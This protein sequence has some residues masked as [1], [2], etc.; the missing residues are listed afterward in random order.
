[1][2]LSKPQLVENIARELSDNSTGQISPYDIRHNL[3]D[4][5]DSVHLLTGSQNLRAK[6]FDTLNAR[7][8]RAG[9]FTIDKLGLEGYFSTDNSAFGYFALN[10]NY[11][12]AKNTAVGSYSL[13]CN[14]YGEDN[15]ALGYHALAGNTNGF[16][17]IGI[18]SYTLNN[19]KIGNFNIAIG[20][21]A[22]YYAERDTNFR[23]F[24]ASHAIDEEY[25][26]ANESGEGL[27]PLIH[28]DLSSSNLR[29]GI[30]TR[31]LHEGATLQVGGNVHPTISGLSNFD[32]GS[33]NYRWRNIYLTSFISFP[34]NNHILFNTSTNKFSISSDTAINGNVITSGNLSVSNNLVTSGNSVLGG[35]VHIDGAAA[36]DGGI[37]VSG[38][39]IPQQHMAFNLGDSDKFWLNAYVNNIYVSGIG[40]FNRFEAI[41]QAHYLHK[42]MFLASSGYVES[43]DGGGPNGLYDYYSPNDESMEPQGYLNDEEL[44]GAGLNIKSSG[45]DYDRTYKFVFKPTDWSLSNLASDSVYSRSSWNSNISISTSSGCHVQ[46]SRLI[47]KNNVGV[48]TYDDGLGLYIRDGKIY[49][50][51]NHNLS[52]NLAG[53]SDVNYISNSG[54]T[55]NYV[56][57]ISSPS[58]GVNLSQRFL[59]NVSNNTNTLNGFELIYI[60]DSELNAPSF[61]N[62]DAG[63]YP[64]RF[65]VRSF[66]NSNSAKRSF[67]LLQDAADGFVGISN[68]E[69]SDYLLPD[70]ILNIRS[71]G[72]AV[73]RIT[74]ENQGYSKSAIQLLGVENCLKYGAELEYL[75][76]SGIVN[77]N[78]FNNEQYR[79]V[80]KIF[81]DDPLVGIFAGSGNINSMLTIGDDLNPNAIVALHEASSNPI[82][83]SGYGKV[84][85]KKLQNGDGKH[86]SLQFMDASGNMFDIT[87]NAIGLDGA[88]N[89]DK[90]LFVDDFGNTFGGRFSPEQKQTIVQAQRNTAI[91]FKSLM[92]VTDG[93]NNTVI[94]YQAGSGITTGNNNIVLGYNSLQS[95]STGSNNIVIGNNLLNDVPENS[96]DLFMLG[97]QN[98]VLMSGQLN[99]QSIT[100]PNGTLMIDN[101]I[102]ESLKLKSNLIEVVDRGGSD[103]PDSRLIFKFTGNSSSDMLI[104][105]HNSGPINKTNV[106][107]QVP[108]PPRPRAELN[109]DLRMLGAIRFSDS[110]SLESASFLTNISTLTTGLS[111]TNASLNNNISNFNTLRS[112]YDALIVEGYAQENILAPSN[113]TNATTGRIR[114]KVKINGAWQD[115]PTSLGDNGSITIHNR[116]TRLQINRQDYVIAIKVNGEYRPLWV[117]YGS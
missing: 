114:L 16:S 28:G 62:E 36:I 37:S 98:K 3:L 19:N 89:L 116:D 15:A 81:V 80:L 78:T 21:G 20:H 58:S 24:I 56:I 93:D 52:S 90:P 85:V 39:I 95:I 50:T 6:N 115:K 5:I 32:I 2:I 55:S 72:D 49:N 96:S 75:N 35:N 17:N 107:Y 86:S 51:F 111:A 26:C 112:E 79:N 38:S 11:Q 44:G 110:T 108:S 46:S 102:G 22:G 31:D 84:F 30:A 87:M 101:N 94:G 74:A 54:T 65:V 91:G 4:I 59:S 7:S 13:S 82:A 14:I 40:R 63:Q 68:F 88:Q 53:I 9:D 92:K 64:S 61:F 106:S 18:G 70:T 73:T 41:E 109:A 43:I 12:G 97:Y 1:M 60:N 77:L 8:T 33:S 104:L 27:V 71:T 99:N 117:S 34:N 113:S 100:M 103:Y 66:N 57:T 29:V 10:A 105:N 47:S 25:L 23:L 76:I 48:V 67:T 45:I 83:A 69:N 42:T